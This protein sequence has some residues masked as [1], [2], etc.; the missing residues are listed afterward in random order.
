MS[1]C[2]NGKLTLFSREH[3]TYINQI[4]GDETIR[5][6]IK[7]IYA[8][9]DWEFVVED[10]NEDFEYSNHHVLVKPDN[11]GKIVKWC[12][13]DEGLQNIVKNKNDTL[14]QSYTLMKYLNKPI[15]TNMKK[16]Q[17]DMIRMYRNIIKRET[18]QRELKGII[19]VM[20]QKIRKNKKKNNQS[21]W[22]DYTDEPITYLHKTYKTVYAEINSV[23]DKW[24][25]YGYWF[26]IKTGV[27][28]KK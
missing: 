24:E 20:R 19:E 28:G 21:L 8:D 16:R 22:K 6:I 27:C 25:K 17:M 7:E 12:S 13:V 14:C 10:A 1:H 2:T 3:Y 11:S 5:E 9:R 23:L 15:V 18:F 26:F 4:F